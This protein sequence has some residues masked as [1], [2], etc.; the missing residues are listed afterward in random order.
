MKGFGFGKKGGQHNY[1]NDTCSKNQKQTCLAFHRHQQ[2][3]Y[4][5][6]HT[7][8]DAILQR[9]LCRILEKQDKTFYRLIHKK[10]EC[11]AQNMF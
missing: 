6:K 8:D 1:G 7:H 2:T 10:Q 4:C 11:H 5:E 9:N 3:A